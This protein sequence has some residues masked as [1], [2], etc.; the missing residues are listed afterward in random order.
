MNVDNQNSTPGID[1]NLIFAAH[2]KIFD[3]IDTYNH[4]ITSGILGRET[5]NNLMNSGTKFLILLQHKDSDLLQD[6][7]T[8]IQNNPASKLDDLMKTFHELINAKKFVILQDT[9]NLKPHV[10]TTKKTQPIV[11]KGLNFQTLNKNGAITKT[12]LPPNQFTTQTLTKQQD[13]RIASVALKAFQTLTESLKSLNKEELNDHSLS[14]RVTFLNQKLSGTLKDILK[15]LTALN[16]SFLTKREARAE[17][18]KLD[19]KAQEKRDEIK[20]DEQKKEL[21]FE[22]KIESYIK[23][24][25][26]HSDE[27][28]SLAKGETPPKNLSQ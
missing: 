10:I 21:Q 18:L 23:S 16:L 8:I 1:N 7:K 4:S 5:I 9:P 19:Q 6:M 11:N 28:K 12:I 24:D 14:G 25:Q 15:N 20:R 13:A 3:K 17:E 22:K 2:N 27:S 26:I